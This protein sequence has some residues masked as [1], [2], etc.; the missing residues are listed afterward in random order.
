[1]HLKGEAIHNLSMPKVTKTREEKREESRRQILDAS[2][3]LFYEKG[4]DAT[5]TRDIIH[6]TGI[7]NGSLYNR[8]PSKEDILLAI[9][10][11]YLDDAVVQL[12][13]VSADRHPA[14]AFAIPGSLLMY[15]SSHSAKAAE[16]VYR[17]SCSMA[18]VDMYMDFYRRISEDT[19]GENLGDFFDSELNRMKVSS[20]IGMVGNMCGRYAAG[21]TVD[22]KDALAYVIHMVSVML[23]VPVFDSKA[24]VDD[25][26]QALDSM[27]ISICGHPLK[28]FPD[29]R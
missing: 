17:A 9:L 18:A 8:F 27:D 28:G 3:V 4:Y 11:E 2:M 6:K 20:I 23:S 12:R 1:M 25:V 5:T 22:F 13:S 21:Y 14:V 19:F 15:V 16:L 7:L 29:Y 10:E 26:S 24:L